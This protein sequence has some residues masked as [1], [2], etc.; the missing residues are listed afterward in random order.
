MTPILL[1]QVL[2]NAP[3]RPC[4]F[5]FSGNAINQESAPF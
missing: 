3:Y 4:G 1:P 2:V 5:N